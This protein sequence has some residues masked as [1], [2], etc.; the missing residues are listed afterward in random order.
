MGELIRFNGLNN[1]ADP[2]RGTDVGLKSAQSWE[3][4][5]LAENVDGTD[6][7]GLQRREGY[8]QFLAGTLSGAFTTF[9]FNRMYVINSGAL[10]RVYPDG[11][12][13]VLRTGLVGTAYWAE[14]NDVVYLSCG[15]DK[16]QIELDNTVRDWGLPT[17]GQPTVS[18]ASGVLQPGVVQVCLTFRDAS[19]REGGASPAIEIT[20]S[21]GVTVSAIPHVSGLSTEVYATESDG[22]VFYHVASLTTQTAFTLSTPAYGQELV[23]QFLDS[24]PGEGS[25]I[26]FFAAQVYVAQYLPAQEQTVVWFSQPLGYHL[27]NLN[28]DY[29][30]V[31]GEVVQLHGSNDTLLIATRERVFLYDGTNLQ[32]AAEY[33]VTPGQHADLGSDEKIYF[34]TV[35][36][37]C[38]AA[39]F[40]NLTEARVSIAPGVKAGGG[41]ISK[42]GYTKYVAIINKGGHAFNARSTS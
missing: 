40:E 31:P 23:T 6:S 7:G 41:V 32:Q 34:W 14:I 16:L 11:S 35:R 15:S 30:I 9:D 19:G 36:G 10:E 24:P 26:A 39:P 3:W 2:M 4:Q 38:R 22:T 29:L 37:L 28:S 21:G 25:L 12:T 18:S 5:S 20:C 33:G 1:I 42:G 8:T 13:Q 27:F 17:P